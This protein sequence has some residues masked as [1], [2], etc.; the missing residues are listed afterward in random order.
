MELDEALIWTSI[1]LAVSRRNFSRLQFLYAQL[2]IHREHMR[3]A[4]ETATIKA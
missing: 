3:V 2:V 4:K 1:D